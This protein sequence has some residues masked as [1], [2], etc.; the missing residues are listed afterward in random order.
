[1]A[2]KNVFTTHQTCVRVPF[3]GNVILL[4]TFFTL[5]LQFVPVS[6]LLHLGVFSSRTTYAARTISPQLMQTEQS[7]IMNIKQN[8]FNNGAGANNHPGGLWINWLYGSS[9]L[10]TNFDT[11][12][13]TDQQQGLPLRHDPLTD[14][15]Y[16]NAL[17]MYKSQYPTDTQFDDQIALYTPIVKLDYAQTDDERGW[18]YDEEFI[19]LYNLSGDEE[20]KND[21]LSLIRAYSKHFNAQVGTIFRISQAH[22]HG[23]YRVDIALE[24]GCALLQAGTEFNNAL[25][26]Q[27]GQSIVD[28]VYQH[29]YVAGDH[30]FPSQMDN[31]LLNTD[32]DHPVVNPNET[33]LLA[34]SQAEGDNNTQGSLFRMGGIAQIA[35]SLVRVYQVTH[36]EIYLNRALDLLDALSLPNNSLGLWDIHNQGYFYGGIFSGSGPSNPGTLTIKADEKEPGRQAAMLIAFHLANQVTGNRYQDMER[37]MLA[38][39]L[40]KAYYA[41]GHGVLYEVNPDW[42]PKVRAG[43]PQTWVTTEAMGTMLEALLFLPQSSSAS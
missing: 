15:R 16:L 42:S 4:C 40:N 23:Y 12:G 11:N 6:D 33:F 18:L 21:A 34:Q 1:M 43:T 39:L 8:G 27:Q 10:Q 5:L 38:V 28:F 30:T 22:P 32:K 24:E 3:S 14:I 26:S 2:T 29:A 17:W 13:K 36:Q 19:S 7:I 9:P 31:V 37:Q 25:W 20:Y 41:Q 35:T